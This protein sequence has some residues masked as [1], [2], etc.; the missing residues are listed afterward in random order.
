MLFKKTEDYI[1]T[2]RWTQGDTAPL[3]VIGR[4]RRVAGGARENHLGGFASEPL[5]EVIKIPIGWSC[6]GNRDRMAYLHEA[7]GV[8][9]RIPVGHIIRIIEFKFLFKIQTLIRIHH[10]LMIS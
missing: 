4:H 10:N 6:L 2:N 7:E 9:F 5:E 3:G 8:T 1:N